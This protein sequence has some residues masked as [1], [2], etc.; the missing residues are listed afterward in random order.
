MSIKITG[1]IE[2]TSYLLRDLYI[3][4]LNIYKNL[5]LYKIIYFIL[6]S[7]KRHLYTIIDTMVQKGVD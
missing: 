2:N 4:V 1:T 3:V 7:I 6:Q 5:T